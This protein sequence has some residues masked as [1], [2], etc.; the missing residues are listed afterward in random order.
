MKILLA[1][2]VVVLLGYLVV[3]VLW[4]G[5]QILVIYIPIGILT[6]GMIVLA[7]AVVWAY[8]NTIR[9]VL[10]WAG[11]KRN[12]KRNSSGTYNGVHGYHRYRTW[13]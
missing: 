6:I 8:I 1:L 10:R 13:R 12:G 9:P 5:F 3:N 2:F 11:R 7:A 4:I